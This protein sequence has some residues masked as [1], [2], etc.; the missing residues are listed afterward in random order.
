[1]T[2]KPNKATEL[3][4]LNYAVDENDSIFSHQ[5]Q[6]L[7]KLSMKISSEQEKKLIRKI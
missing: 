6:I 2:E 7:K 3:L 5:A 1:M 4:L